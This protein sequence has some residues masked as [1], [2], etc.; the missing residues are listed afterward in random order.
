MNGCPSAMPDLQVPAPAEG[1]RL[2]LAEVAADSALPTHSTEWV[3]RR[4]RLVTILLAEPIWPPSGTAGS[5]AEAAWLP[6]PGAFTTLAAGSR[7][8]GKPSL[9]GAEARHR[10]P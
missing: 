2:A 3:R 6:T 4:L 7:P 5:C 1:G 8:A 10:L 9:N